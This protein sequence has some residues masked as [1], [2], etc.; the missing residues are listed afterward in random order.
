MY[1][2]NVFKND[3][4]PN[5]AIVKNIICSETGILRVQN[6]SNQYEYQLE[7]P[8]GGII[9]YQS[10]PE[11]AGLTEPGVYTINVRQNNGL[12]TAC[13]FKDTEFMEI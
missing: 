7:T 5:L 8:T 10:S 4:T 3:F 6:S 2:F 1:Y 9:G 12:S 13:V 11:F